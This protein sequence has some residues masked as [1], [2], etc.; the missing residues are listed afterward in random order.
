MG[1][2]F[3]MPLGMRR[4]MTT[5]RHSQLALTR[6]RALFEDMELEVSHQIG[7]A[8][9]DVEFNY[10]VA[11]TRFNSWAASQDEVNAVSSIYEAGRVTLDLLLDAQRRRALAE[12]GFYRSLADYNRAVMRLHFY[13]GTLLEYNGVYLAEGPWPGKAHFDAL[14][15][16]RQ[17]DASLF[18]NYGFTRP[19]VISRGQYQQMNGASTGALIQMPPTGEAGAPAGQ[20]KPLPAPTHEELIPT[21][22]VEPLLPPAAAS[23]PTPLANSGMQTVVPASAI[24]SVPVLPSDSAAGQLPPNPFLQAPTAANPVATSP[25]TYQPQ[26]YYPLAQPAAEVADS[27]WEQR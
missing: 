11:Q 2:Q 17:R 22:A 20:P 19:Q 12:S 26:A 16:A 4:G 9:R 27:A 21:P 15:R 14:R 3:T 5:V 13:K 6:E 8:F 18:M 25:L 23:V 24:E 10:G 7:Q 1:L